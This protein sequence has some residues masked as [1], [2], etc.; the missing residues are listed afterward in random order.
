M[1]ASEWDA[2]APEFD[3]DVFDPTGTDLRGAVPRALRT[4]G[5][6]DLAV[7]FG[8]GIGRLL[9]SLVR[10]ADRVVG[11]DFAQALLDR[12]HDRLAGAP[13]VEL[14][15]ADLSRPLRS[16]RGAGLVCCVNVLL[17][18]DARVR[19][20]IGRNLR[21]ALAE[22]GHL[23][24]VVPSLESAMWVNDRL[25]AANERDGARGARA[26]RGGIGTDARSARDL[27]RGV[28]DQ[29]SAR[30]KHY[31][32]EECIVELRALGL[33]PVREDRVEYPWDAYLDHAPRWL[34]EPLPWDWLFLARRP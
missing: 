9:P 11:L 22:G 19:R 2:L 24:L 33:E 4:V 16:P 28:V 17:S 34:G 25:I 21:N 30:T 14:R 5:R 27:L 3:E 29:G 7:D 18:P 12:A 15:R 8:C 10:R 6:V 23:L 13:N 31:L 1:K 26:L 32:R 20:G